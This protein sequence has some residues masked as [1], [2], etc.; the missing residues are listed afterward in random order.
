[1]NGN[2][3]TSPEEESATG[4]PDK[5]S[6]S[7][8]LRREVFRRRHYS[9]RVI[10]GC[11][12]IVYSHDADADRA[13]LRDVLDYPHVDAGADWL[14]FKLPPAEIAVHPVDGPPG[15]ELYMMCDNLDA[16]MAQLAAKGIRFAA[17]TEARWG[18][19]TRLRLPSG[20]ELGMYEPRHPRATDL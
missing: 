14:I 12:V 6:A 9:G 2:Y 13:F 1:M 11:H 19:L 10:N 20:G 18:R 4:H 3:S 5:R 8:T 17:V 15:H 16:T 7:G